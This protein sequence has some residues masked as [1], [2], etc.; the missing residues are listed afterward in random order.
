MLGNKSAR[1]YIEEQKTKVLKF[2]FLNEKM[3]RNVLENKIFKGRGKHMKSITIS[4]FINGE[5]IEDDNV[6]K[7]RYIKNPKTENIRNTLLSEKIN[8][9]QK[10]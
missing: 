9:K 10:K 1:I 7:Y 2:L 4:T 8:D 6:F 3:N 5:V